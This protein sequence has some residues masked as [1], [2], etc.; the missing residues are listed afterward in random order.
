[1]HVYIYIYVYQYKHIEIDEGIE[2]DDMDGHLHITPAYV[3]VHISGV[4]FKTI[5]FWGNSGCNCMGQRR[6]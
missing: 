4:D 6:E 3:D 5:G 2:M 1:M